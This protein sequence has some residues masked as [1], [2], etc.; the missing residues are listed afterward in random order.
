M[1]DI[2]NF[3]YSTEKIPVMY[4]WLQEKAKWGENKEGVPYQYVDKRYFLP[5]VVAREMGVTRQ[6]IYNRMEWLENKNWIKVTD[7]EII[8]L[9]AI[10]HD[11]DEIDDEIV[12][13]FNVLGVDSDAII[14][15][16]YLKT[17]NE[18]HGFKGDNAFYFSRLHIIR[19]V[20]KKEP[21]DTL[22]D[23]L[24]AI[25]VLLNSLG[26]IE[27]YQDVHRDRIYVVDVKDYIGE[28]HEGI[29][30]TEFKPYNSHRVLF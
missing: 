7:Q 23:K 5:A 24:D 22:Y 25:L 8:L 29:P 10:G 3:F 12:A 9:H 14:I 2:S 17:M 1:F 6:T 28:E 16:N 18:Y 11:F 4:E 26:L 20:L 13:F 30:V 21:S 27:C 15:Y 19:R